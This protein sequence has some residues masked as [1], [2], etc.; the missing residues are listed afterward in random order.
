MTYTAR[1]LNHLIGTQGFRG[2]FA[3]LDEALAYVAR[4][5]AQTRDFV[6]YEVCEGTPRDYGKLVKTWAPLRGP[7]GREIKLP[8]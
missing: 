8:R 6:S 7:G 1:W 5:E 2:T 4:E 3:T